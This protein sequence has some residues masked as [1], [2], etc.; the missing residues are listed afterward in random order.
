MQRGVLVGAGAILILAI[1]FFGARSVTQKQAGAALDQGIAQ[2]LTQL[3]PGY[4]V[5]HGTTDVNPLTRAVTVH[6]LTLTK[7]GAPVMSAAAFT[8]AGADRRA[9]QDVFDP[10]AYPQGRPAWTD[11][12]LL[13]ADASASNVQFPAH[14]PQIGVVTVKSMTLH[15]LSGRPFV[16]PPTPQNRANPVFGADAALAMSLDSATLTGVAYLEQAPKQGAA[17]IESITVSDYD[18]G[19]LGSA[20]L[21]AAAIHAPAKPGGPLVDL[22]LDHMDA[23]DVD[24]R[25]AL[26]EIRRIGTS[27]RASLAKISYSS[28]AAGGLAMHVPAGPDMSVSDM[29]AE[30]GPLAPDGGRA[31]RAWLHG[32][33]LALG[34]MAIPPSAQPALSAFGM[35]ALTM[36]I[37]AQ[38]HSVNT[39]GE[40]SVREDVALH[41]LGTLHVD[42][43]LGGLNQVAVPQPVPGHPEGPMMA[44]VIDRATLVWDDASLTNRLLAVAAAQLHTTP[45]LVR[46]QLAMPVISLGLM[47]PDQPDAAD[48]VTTF[49][50][51]PHRLTVTMNPPQKISIG[52]IAQAP[53]TARAHLLGVHIKAD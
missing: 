15:R 2:M 37:D 20:A 7:D 50:T 5:R 31:G 53:V 16:M 19:K 4:A 45:E 32:M 23:K 22:A 40:T 24:A 35:T 46:A 12:R 28:A 3:P 44:A 27:D 48:Q 42:A 43:E 11:R 39:A 30:Q 49:L 10:D 36:D 41:D 1:G 13:I 25:A 14:P 8:V 29:R 18:A 47:I 9:L 21:R 51:H 6:D 26:E 52:E 33:V 34:Q 38:G 17:S